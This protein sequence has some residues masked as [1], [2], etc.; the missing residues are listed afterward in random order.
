MPSGP[1]FNAALLAMSALKSGS[2]AAEAA[3]AQS[4][5]VEASDNYFAYE[6]VL[7]ALQVP[8]LSRVWLI[9]IVCI[10]DTVIHFDTL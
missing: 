9:I 5:L 7:G 2:A 1:I 4:M 6:P 8:P 10:S 3:A